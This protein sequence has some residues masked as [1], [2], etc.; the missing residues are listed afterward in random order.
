MT[1]IKRPFLNFSSLRNYLPRIIK[2]FFTGIAWIV[3][4]HLM[5]ST[6]A[7][8]NVT[9][10]LKDVPLKTVIFEIERQTD[11][12]FVFDEQIIDI[13]MIVNVK[14]NDESVEQALTKALQNTDVSFTVEGRNIVLKKASTQ[15]SS[16]GNVIQKQKYT[17]TGIVTDYDGEPIIGATIR[18]KSS[19]QGTIT[20]FNGMFEL[21][22]VRDNILHIS[23]IGYT[24]LDYKIT[25]QKNV[26]IQLREEVKALEEIVVVGY[27][28]L[29]RGDITSSISSLKR[30]DFLQGD[31]SSPL[32][33]V[34]GKVAGLIINTIGGDPTKDN[35][36]VQMMLRGV[37]NLSGNQQPLIVVDGIAGAS[38]ATI[39]PDDVESIDILKD[40]SAAAIYGTRGN[41]GVI[42]VTTKKGVSE[43]KSKVNVT[44]HGYASYETIANRIDMFNASEFLSIP[45]VTAGKALNAVTDLK[46]DTDW[47]NA[48]YQ[49]PINQNHNI[50]IRSGDAMSNVVLSVNYLEQ[51]GILKN[52]G[53]D[54]LRMRLATNQSVWEGKLRFFGSAVGTI[55]NSSYVNP[56]IYYNTLLVNPTAAARDSVTN[57]SYTFFQDANNP[58]QELNEKTTDT[59]WNRFSLNGKVTL[60]PINDLNISTVGSIER[61]Q[62]IEGVFATYEYFNG[63]TRNGEVWRNTKFDE[64]KTFEL[65]ADYSFTIN[66]SHKTTMLM[67]YSYQEHN[68]EGFNLYNYDYPTELLSYNKPGLGLA[69]K[70]GNAGMDGYKAKSKLISGFARVNYSFENKYIASL[71][72]RREGS[73]KF[74]TNNKWGTFPSV[75]V[76][77][78]ISN[79]SFLK[80]VEWLDNLKARFGYGITG[81]EPNNV[82]LSINR[83]SYSNPVLSDGSW[84]WS[85]GPSVN[86]NPDLR[87]ET[88]KE[89]NFGIDY[90]LFHGRFSG[91]VDLYNRR[92]D[93]LIYTYQVPVPPNLVSDI[94]ANVGSITNSGVEFLISGIP[95]Q[96][97][98]F[99]WNI[100]TN[101]S[102]NKNMLTKLSN[103]MYQR[104]FLELGATG[105]PI[106]KSTHIVREGEPIGNFFG[107]KSASIADDG[108]KWLDAEGNPITMENS[109]REILG[110]GIPNFFYG[111]SSSFRYKAFDASCS[112]RGVGG[113]QILNQYRMLHETFME[114]G[115]QNY[116]KTILNK[117]YGVDTYV[118]TAPSYVSY[119]VENGDYLKL[120]NVTLGY[121]IPFKKY[122]ENLRFYISGLNLYTF[123][124]YLGIDPEVNILGL[125]PGIDQIGG[126]Y[127]STRSISV[128]VQLSL[129]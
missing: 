42:I 84:I 121:S 49:T 105:A 8:K 66:Q 12:L 89:L 68:W 101:F 47:F 32:S 90:S 46:H 16:P 119:F 112:L 129:F 87:W 100:A 92:T 11:F 17:I 67:G 10:D 21:E 29:K 54:Q 107:W 120:D 122:I 60:E 94:Y 78:N 102:F 3:A 55:V 108:S 82:Y 36:G 106:Q 126:I 33:L 83:Y 53:K 5:A 38:L 73:T 63:D 93:D 128:G 35:G 30:E 80:D 59:K 43:G 28:S 115:N 74:G 109:K 91:S 4:T 45:E 26:V 111:I 23:Y 34:K 96:T 116:P 37:S 25:N 103:E 77:W 50:S 124:K 2:V 48:I 113:F 118:Y 62:H 69:L 27:G 24:A 52:S 72:V 64:L 86:N 13:N 57:Y 70:E 31:I 22:V 7:Q 117:P 14:A 65:L 1:K 15:I 85:V 39:S 99:S 76:G 41:N 95:V 125:S 98:N 19:D 71:S 40:G 44:Y 56:S 79:E 18:I 110:N 104:D 61:F 114:G 51:E 97:K 127:P 123:T 58:V 75:S 6:A 20:N 9:F 81:A 88:K